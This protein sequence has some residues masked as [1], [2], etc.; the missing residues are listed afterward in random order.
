MAGAKQQ[1]SLESEAAPV[2][3]KTTVG[4]HTEHLH[5]DI[6]GLS[7]VGGA[8]G[9]IPTFVGCVIVAGS[10]EESAYFS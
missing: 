4:L 9:E 6:Q 8:L 10:K 3:R 2:A 7:S 5:H 1:A